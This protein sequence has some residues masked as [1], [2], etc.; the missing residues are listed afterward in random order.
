MTTSLDTTHELA[1]SRNC[2]F[3]TCCVALAQTG[4]QQLC[5][6]LQLRPDGEGFLFRHLHSDVNSLLG[7][8]RSCE[9][10]LCLTN[11]LAC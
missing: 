6:L 9:S 2:E 7:A 3:N 8:T 10:K 11:M 5:N 1:A 4:R